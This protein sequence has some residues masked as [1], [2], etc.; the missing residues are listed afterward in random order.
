MSFPD[1]MMRLTVKDDRIA[2]DFLEAVLLM[3][4]RR[5][6]MRSAAGTSGSLEKD[7]PPNVEHMFDPDSIP[8]GSRKAPR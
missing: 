7:Q 8:E 2:K 5:H 6:M 1:T 3:R 4:G